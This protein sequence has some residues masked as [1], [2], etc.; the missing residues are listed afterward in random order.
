[1]TRRPSPRAV[2]L[3]ASALGAVTLLTTAACVRDGDGGS[4]NSS[5]RRPAESAASP[6]SPA[7]TAAQQT[8][9]APTALT[10]TQAR[11]AL[12]TP[13]DLGAPWA[14]TKGSAL[15]RDA[16][17]KGTA[18]KADCGRLLDSVYTEELLG[19]PS[20]AH[21]VVGFDDSA[22]GDQLHY[23]VNA[24]HR[25]D[26]DKRLGWLRTM[27]QKCGRFTAVGTGGARQ[28]VRVT[29][30]RL[31]E[32]G[33]ARQGLRLSTRGKLEGAR[34]TLTLDLAAVRV[35][36]DAIVLTNGGLREPHTEYTV[37]AVQVG[38]ERLKQTRNAL[39]APPQTPVS[40]ESQSQSPT[41]SPNP[42][43][44]PTPGQSPSPTRGPVRPQPPQP[45][46]Q[47]AEGDDWEQ[48]SGQDEDL[49]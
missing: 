2:R 13:T 18:D 11:D 29:E 16:L 22:E 14:P 38:A 30:V 49:Y 9:T 24:A 27:P 15:W 10:D 46:Q 47:E 32:A 36:D 43:T 12:L 19:E 26:V 1:M 8:S 28:E 25:A 3:L 34:A 7:S 39:P 6:T 31:P 17:L 20:G 35:G 44:S 37:Q 33:D 45:P 5:Q 23:Q 42:S 41:E 4:G 40:G 21:A 48:D